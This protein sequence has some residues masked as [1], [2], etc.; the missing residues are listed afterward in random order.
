MREIDRFA[1][2]FTF[3]CNEDVFEYSSWGDG[4]YWDLFERVLITGLHIINIKMNCFRN[5]IIGQF[6]CNLIMEFITFQLNI[7]INAYLSF[8]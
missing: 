7:A 2:E 6:Y 4:D 8:K 3:A 5:M 1:M